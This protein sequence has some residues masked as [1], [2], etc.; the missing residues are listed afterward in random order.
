MLSNAVFVDFF[1]RIPR[2][3]L[4]K[5]ARKNPSESSLSNEGIENNRILVNYASLFLL[6]ELGHRRG[7]IYNEVRSNWNAISASNCRSL[8]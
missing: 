1:D 8:R 2:A 7:R 4:D 3:I 5:H 6:V